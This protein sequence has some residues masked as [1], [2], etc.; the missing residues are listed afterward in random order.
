MQRIALVLC[1]VVLVL[2]LVAPAAHGAPAPPLYTPPVDAPVVDP[3]RPPAGPYGSGN[4]GLDATT[5]RP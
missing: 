2:G 1:S 5:L 4:R 3:F